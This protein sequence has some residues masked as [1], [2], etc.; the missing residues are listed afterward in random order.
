MLKGAQKRMVMLRTAD[1]SLFETAYF[2]LRDDGDASA[3]TKQPTMLE[4]ANRILDQ[5]FTPRTAAKGKN[6]NITIDG[7]SSLVSIVDGGEG[8]VMNCYGFVDGVITEFRRVFNPEKEEFDALT[9]CKIIKDGKT[10]K[11]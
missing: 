10:Y 6:G 9:P 7:V 4:E 1:S 2:I 8:L 11:V 5:S 3:D